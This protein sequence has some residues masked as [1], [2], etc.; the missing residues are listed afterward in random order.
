[1]NT[2]LL[3]PPHCIPDGDSAYF[4]VTVTELKADQVE[5]EVSKEVVMATKVEVSPPI[6]HE[7]DGRT[8]QGHVV[9]TYDAK[10]LDLRRDQYD[11]IYI[12]VSH[13]TRKIKI[14]V[15]CGPDVRI[16]SADPAV[17]RTIAL[18]R[19]AQDA[20][21]KDVAITTKAAADGDYH[22]EVDYPPTGSQVIVKLDVRANREGSRAVPSRG[23]PNSATRRRKRR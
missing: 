20:A 6:P 3:F 2:N 11:T 12:D 10:A 4:R 8:A 23:K 19:L 7:E 15:K 21:L 22:I 17:Q 5:E 18:L 9:S 16:Q 13:P 14:H 1:M